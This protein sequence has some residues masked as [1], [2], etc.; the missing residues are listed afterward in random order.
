MMAA[1]VILE[2]GLALGKELENRD[3]IGPA[4]CGL[5]HLALR[6]GEL[7]HERSLYEESIAQ[8]Q[9]RWLSPRIKWVLACCLEGLAEI[10]LSQGN[11]AWTVQLYASAEMVRAAHGYYSPLGKEQPYY[12]R[13]LAAARTQLGEE[14]FT[15]FWT[16]GHSTIP[17]P[18]PPAHEEE[19]PA[20]P[21]SLAS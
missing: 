18:A 6:Q 15:A 11:A 2:D 5:G 8:I 4:L 13:T 14:S 16:R 10:A 17:D 9:G 7:A 3:D 1:Y 19:A 20:D 21:P 12:K